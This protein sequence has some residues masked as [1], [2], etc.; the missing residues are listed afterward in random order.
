M[1]KVISILLLVLMV[2]AFAGIAVSADAVQTYLKGD[3]DGDGIVTVIDAT[4]IQRLLVDLETDKDG[5]MT[6]RGN[7][8]GDELDILDA[9]YIQRFLVDFDD[10]YAI[11]TPVEYTP[12]TVDPT[13]APATDEPTAEPTE[14]PT[15]AVTEAPTAAPTEAPTAAVTEAPTAA[16][17]EPE[18]QSATGDNNELPFVPA[19]G[20]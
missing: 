1:K 15:A 11:N 17:T 7:V 18:T 9:T 16:V 20:N 6:L 5:M 8:H 12:P 14:A 3:T 2:S 19:N 13:I 4:K 10:G